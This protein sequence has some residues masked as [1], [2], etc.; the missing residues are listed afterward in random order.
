MN[1]E[2][3]IYNVKV[4]EDERGSFSPSFLP[5]EFP[6]FKIVQENTVF[7]KEPYIFRGLHWQEPPYDQAKFLRC[8]F[9]D[10]IDFAVDIRKDSPNYGTSYSFRLVKPTDWVYIPRGFAHGYITLPNKENLPT[11]VEYKVDNVY[12]K[13]SER[14]M[15]LTKYIHDTICIELPKDK[16]INMNKRDLT[17]PTIDEIE[18]NFK[19]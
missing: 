17:W 11:I 10:I 8:L 5:E 1:L 15:F 6:G 7:T 2:P 13:E 3:F 14:G 19:Y 12:N 9:G 16:E 4:F 18:S